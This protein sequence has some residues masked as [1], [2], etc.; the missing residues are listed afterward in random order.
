[1]KL[2]IGKRLWWLSLLF[3]F[4]AHLTFAQSS[5]SISGTVQD[6][7]GAIIPNATVTAQNL[8]T[9]ATTT[10][11]TNDSG[12]YLIQVPAGSYKIQASATGFQVLVHDNVIVDAL[13]SVPLNMTLSVG[14][15]TTQV[16]VSVST[17]TIQTDNTTLGSTLRNEV[18]AALP[19]QMS[20]GVP[21]DPTSF[22][23]LAPGVAAVV[24]ESAGPSFTSFN[25]GQQEVNG[26]YF[27]DLP[28]SF[29]NQMGDTRPIALAVSVD[30]VN[31]FQVEINGEKAEYQGQGFHNYVLKSGTN[32]F[33]GSLFEFFRNT[34]LD[35]KSYFSTFVPPDHQNEYGGNVGGPIRKNLFFFVNYDGYQFNTTSSPQS[36]TI[37][38]ALERAGNFSELT[39]QLYDPFTQSCSGTVCTKVAYSTSGAA[40]TTATARA[41]DPLYNIIPASE[42]ATYGGISRS[43][44]SYLPATTGSGFVNNYSNPLNRAISNRNITTRVDYNISQKN[45]LYG[46]FAYGKWST[47]YTGNLTPTGTALPLP[48][49]Q[50][51]GIVIERPLIAQLHETAVLSQSLVNNIGIG[52]V[53][54]SIPIF[55]ITQAGKYPQA[56]GLTGLPGSG[57]AANGFPGINFSGSNAPASWAGSGPFNEWENDVVAQDALTWVRGQHAFKFGFTFQTTQDNRG[58]PADGTSATFSF[59]SNETAGFAANSS[60]LLSNTGNSYASFLLGAVDSSSITNNAVVETGSRFHNYSLFAQDDWKVNSVLTLN[61]GLRWDVYAPFN[62]QHNRFSFALPTAP[63]PA[64]NNIGGA[65]VYGQQLVPTHYKNFQPRVGLAYQFD[66]KTVFRAGFII[67]DTM[68]TLGVGGNGPNGPGQNGYNPPTPIRS[69]VTGQP[70]FYWSQGVPTPVTPFPTGTAGF[71]AGNSTTNPS[72]AIAPPILAD[73]NLAGRAQEYINYSA[74][75][76]RQLPA[77]ITLGVAYSGSGGRFLS[78]YGAVGAYSNSMDPKYLAL[79]SLLNAQATASNIAAA[80]SQ[81]PNVGL[82]F[83]NF[84]G[85]IATMLLPFPQ[86]ALGTSCYSCDEGSSSYNS[87]QVTLDRHFSRG[88]T[89]QFTYTL[90]KEIDDMNNSASQLGS[91]TGGTRNPYDHTLDRGLGEIDH[92]HNIHVNW[93]YDLPFGR[94]HLIGG[95]RIANAIVGNWQWSGIYNWETGS[96][97]GVNGTSCQ[98]PGISSSCMVN[99]NPSFTGNVML[100]P[101]G[102]GDAHT[103]VYLNKTAF[104][105]PAPFTFGNEP[106]SAPYG[107]RVPTFWEI[108]STLR[109]TFPIREH[110]SFQLSADFFNLLNNVIFAAPATNIDSSTFGIVTTT[111]NSPRRI[112]FSGR[113][114]F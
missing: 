40:D 70:A 46:V 95:N 50:S 56:A 15:A 111:Q 55:P 52:V 37:P 44:E 35:S 6:S 11:R 23:A 8:G 33:H 114:S 19:L 85:T 98:T 25:G 104:A 93:V 62:E 60:T 30:A 64:A 63:N 100:A 66:K 7:S 14:E 43:F 53:R 90:A 45:Q 94:G 20:Q 99:L 10:G 92:R 29:P 75:F 103:A 71:G 78:R 72:G 105:D 68:G 91:V 88:L 73:A 4:A 42:I 83:P 28:I 41:A 96:P 49:T 34:S 51:P 13:A 77:Q 12:F 61:L 54:L 21:R 36:L 1:M 38:D 84:K 2:T 67:A 102:S 5:G 112:Q 16:E 113:L 81:F 39:T 82:P 26:L 48:Y 69:S 80:Q 27:E 76:Q 106:R 17:D 57:Q 58:S 110:V 107:L 79:G 32:Q 109:R 9:G 74:G 108:D 89:A 59:S 86:Y 97:L 18:Y 24:L 3:I 87:M 31:Q 101:I 47:D 22:I 65:L